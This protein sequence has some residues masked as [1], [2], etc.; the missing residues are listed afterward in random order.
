MI[1]WKKVCYFAGGVIYA[2]GDTRK[3]IING[4]EVAFYK[5]TAGNLYEPETPGGAGAGNEK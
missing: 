3:I 4:R 2:S 1:N 5:V